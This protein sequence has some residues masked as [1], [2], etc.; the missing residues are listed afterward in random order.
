MSILK[1]GLEL[2]V[3][4]KMPLNSSFCFPIP[5]SW[6]Y[7][8]GLLYLTLF[9][10]YSWDRFCYVALAV[11]KL[12]ATL[13]P[14]HLKRWNHRC[15][16]PYPLWDACQVPTVLSTG[17]LD[18]PGCPLKT[19]GT[20]CYLQRAVQRIPSL[21]ILGFWGLAG[22]WVVVLCSWT[23]LNPFPT[24]TL[25]SCLRVSAPHFLCSL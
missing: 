25:P 3:W 12:M 14:Q 13:L 20:S 6:E 5:K 19:V 10:C 4:L 8:L 11:L 15:G 18:K 21:H 7:R 2:C 16:P 9:G 23:R 17:S 1:T 24:R 22:V